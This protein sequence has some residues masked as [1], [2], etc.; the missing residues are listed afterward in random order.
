MLP[1]V[2]SLCAAVVCVD[3]VA[4][5]TCTLAR[6]ALLVGAVAA[7][8]AC[9][10]EEGDEWASVSAELSASLRRARATAIR[11]TVRQRGL[12][13]GAL[14]GGIADAETGLAHCWSEATWACEGPASASC[15]GGPVI[16]GAG[17]GPCALRE[18]GLGMFQFDGGTFDQTLARDGAGVL[19]LEGNI[20][21][22]VDFVLGMV[23]RSQFIEGVDDV[24]AA[25]AWLD[26][27][28]VAPGD[29]RYEAWISTVTRYYNGCSPTS[30]C[31]ASRRARYGDKTE[32][33][34]A[35][36]GADF[37][38]QT[39]EPPPPPP[40]EPCAPVPPEGRVIEEGEGCY[41]RGGGASGWRVVSG[42]GSGGSLEWTYAMAGARDNF[43]VWRLD[44]AQAGRYLIEVHT[45]G[46]TYGQSRQ[47]PYTVRSAGLEAV[48][49]L[50]QAAAPGFVPLVEVD[51]A[52]GGDQW[53]M[54][55]DD[56]G[57]PY[58]D[59]VRLVFDAVRVVPVA[60]VVDVPPGQ[61]TTPG[62]EPAPAGP[63]APLPEVV[64]GEVT[65]P[66]VSPP[67]DGEV[68]GGC[69]CVA[70][71]APRSTT[72]SVVLIF[73]VAVLALSP[74]RPRARAPRR[75]P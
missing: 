59:R 1:A 47:A 30:S 53:V 34:Y 42:E 67:L 49:V 14:L 70:P 54:L 61:V 15:G 19:L 11:D 65:A 16:A 18:G 43:A 71:P 4:M 9:G 63:V 31:W 64:P 55:G 75:G 40:P 41:T 73:A 21:H 10:G 26:T 33:V 48:V 20:D 56:T 72:P 68:S 32:S 8:S 36:L 50:D 66:V 24:A 39:V 3:A 35:E 29:A 5:P 58:A 28:P 25:R 37:W 74:A 57:E 46:G 6:S 38:G 60:P 22:A 45:D 2:H 69:A 52:A 13:A 17:D 51:L 12:G 44:V 23:V 7:A 27:V 62:E